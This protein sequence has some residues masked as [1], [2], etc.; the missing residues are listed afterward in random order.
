MSIASGRKN[1]LRPV[2][3]PIKGQCLVLKKKK[4]GNLTDPY[5]STYYLL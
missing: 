4:N 3:C 2:Q 5:Q 1:L